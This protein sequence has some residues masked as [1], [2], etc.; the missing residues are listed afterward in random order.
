LFSRRYDE[1]AGTPDASRG[2]P[3]RTLESGTALC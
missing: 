2:S 3:D 1:G